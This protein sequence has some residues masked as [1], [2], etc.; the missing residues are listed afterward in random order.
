MNKIKNNTG[1]HVNHQNTSRLKLTFEADNS[2]ARKITTL[3]I[4]L[5]LWVVNVEST[6]PYK[7]FKSLRKL[8]LIGDPDGESLT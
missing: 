8:I 4:R 5:Y 6:Q 2:K 7:A 1:I 3:C